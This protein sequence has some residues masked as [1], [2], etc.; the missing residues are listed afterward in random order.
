MA[1]SSRLTKA[2]TRTS[3]SQLTCSPSSSRSNSGLEMRAQDLLDKTMGK[4]KA[5]VRVTATLDFAKVEKTQELFDGE[6]PVIRSEQVNQ[7]NSGAQTTGGVPGVQSN[8]QGNSAGQSAP[9][10]RLPARIHELPIMKSARPS[11]KSSTRLA[12]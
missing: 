3:S 4:D 10:H 9:P 8:L 1:M 2:L 6:D 11:T 5:M 12:A 7:E